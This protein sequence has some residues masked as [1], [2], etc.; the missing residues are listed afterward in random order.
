MSHLQY[1][2]YKGFGEHMREALS[3]N[4]AV[5]IGDRI[6]ISGQG[7]WDPE[8]LQ[9]HSDLSRETEQ[10]FAN[11]DLALKDAGGKGWSQVYRVR[12]FT[13]EIKNEQATGFLVEN[14]RK[15]MP[16]HKP[17]LTCVGVSELALEGMRVE[18]EAIAQV[19]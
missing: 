4:Q 3:Y 5:R 16:D 18:I 14:L 15:W 1:F 13:T 19:V 8:T 12:I 10:A 2:S 17:V 6:E 9:V 7:G 11:V